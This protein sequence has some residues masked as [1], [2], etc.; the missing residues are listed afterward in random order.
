MSDS[1][2]ESIRDLATAHAID[3][4]DAEDAR[5]FERQL[6]RSEELQRVVAE[7]RVIGALLPLAA[8]PAKPHPT[9]RKRV[10]DRVRQEARDVT[11]ERSGGTHVT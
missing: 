3:A 9:L 2:H 10:L 4:L 8:Q 7:Y 5:A 1:T 6:E 11:P